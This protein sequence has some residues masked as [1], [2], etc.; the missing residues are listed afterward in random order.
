MER[1][2]GPSRPN[3]ITQQRMSQGVEDPKKKDKRK[4]V[5]ER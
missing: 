1:G 5:G 2:A 3:M 4:S